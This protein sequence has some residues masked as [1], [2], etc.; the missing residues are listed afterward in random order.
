MTNARENAVRV[1]TTLLNGLEAVTFTVSFSEEGMGRTLRTISRSVFCR[2]KRAVSV[3]FRRLG[4]FPAR[5]VEAHVTDY[6]CGMVHSLDRL[7][8]REF[9]RRSV[10]A[11]SSER[12]S[13]CLYGRRELV[14]PVDHGLLLNAF[15]VT[16]DDCRFMTP[17]EVLRRCVR[18]TA[19]CRSHNA[20]RG[21]NLI[22]RALRIWSLRRGV[23]GVFLVE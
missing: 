15:L 7:V 1:S 16:A 22:A 6:V 9:R 11:L 18:R 20:R 10:R 21:G 2:V 23:N 14:F 13:V 12:N 19:S 4:E 8:V 17:N 3:N 5:R